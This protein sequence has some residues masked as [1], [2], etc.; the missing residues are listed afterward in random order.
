MIISKQTIPGT[1]RQL[2]TFENGDVLESQVIYMKEQQWKSLK[3]LTALHGNR[4]S[5]MIARL[6]D[7]EMKTLR[8]V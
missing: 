3:I 1:R 7:S 2:C 6:I 5:E 4:T 8:S